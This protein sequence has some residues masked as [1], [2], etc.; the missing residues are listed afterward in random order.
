MAERK[1]VFDHPKISVWCYPEK[2]IVHHQVHAH[3]YGKVFYEALTKGIK[4]LEDCRGTKW[5]SDDRQN[6]PLPPTDLEWADKIWF[7]ETVRA[8]WKYWALVQPESAVGQMNIRR[9]IQLYENRGITV[10][11]LATPEAAMEWLESQ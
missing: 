7:P 9:H 10:E 2:G 1:V 11:I 5:L 3:V 8:G 6:G 4:A